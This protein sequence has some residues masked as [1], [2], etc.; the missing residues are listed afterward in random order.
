[1]SFW[2]VFLLLVSV[3]VEGQSDGSGDGGDDGT[4]GGGEAWQY[5]TYLKTVKYDKT[6]REAERTFY[7]FFYFSEKL[8]N[9]LQETFLAKD[10][11]LGKL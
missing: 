6:L 9:I 8:E 4:D 1:M 7:S 2:I 11:R 10:T 5:V 3:G